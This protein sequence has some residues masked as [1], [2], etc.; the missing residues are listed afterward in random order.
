MR[1]RGRH[2]VVSAITVLLALALSRIA[3]AT[4]WSDAELYAAA[5]ALIVVICLVGTSWVEFA[6]DGAFRRRPQA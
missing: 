1:K 2:Y 3:H 5:A 4:G 6:P